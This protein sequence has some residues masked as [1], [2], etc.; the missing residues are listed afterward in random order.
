[1]GKE[2]HTV[3]STKKRAPR[4]GRGLSSLMAHPVSVIP[5][6]TPEVIEQ[7]PSASAVAGT[8]VNE[9]SVAVKTVA[10]PVTQAHPAIPGAAID[11][12]D[13]TSG[14]VLYVPIEAITPNPQQPRERFDTPALE[15]LA[16]SI[17]AEGLIQPII[18]RP[19]SKPAGTAGGLSGTTLQGQDGHPAYELVAGERRW[20]AAKLAGLAVIP[21]IVRPLSDRQSAQWA[22]VENLQRQDL[23]PIERA[24]AFERLI[25]Q[26]GLS[27]E[28]V[29]DQ[30]GVERP[31]ITN[32]LRLLALDPAVQDMIRQDLL[33]AGQAKAIAAVS[34][35][36]VQRLLA[37]RAVREAWSVRRLESHVREHLGG[38]PQPTADPAPATRAA[39]PR[40]NHL[41]D[42]E[43]Q[44]SQQL[45]TKTALRAGRRKGT[46]SLTIEFYSLD[47]FDALMRRMGVQVS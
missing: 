25:A 37:Q 16:A 20:R 22:L 2:V 13:D 14:R 42:L 12:G 26:F 39:G 38:S 4:L 27:H 43:E 11:R 44:I 46:G 40:A 36:E 29:A 31:T 41:R 47:Q 45:G 21:A 35:H 1:M 33:S 32:A 7:E 23:N 5:P 19:L 24:Q 10:A 17:R 6:T 3:S 15:G 34:E 30:V 18:L 9:S 28:E 8:T